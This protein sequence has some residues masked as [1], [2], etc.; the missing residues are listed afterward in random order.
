M[1]MREKLSSAA[2]ELEAAQKDLEMAQEK[3]N[4]GWYVVGTK[5]QLMEKGLVFKKGFFDDGDMSENVDKSLFKKVDIHE[6]NEIILD[7]RKAKLVT[8][9]PSESYEFIKMKKKVYRLVI[10]NPEKFWSVSKFLIIEVE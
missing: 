5:G 6:L 10:N 1:E 7:S 3:L 8:T 2:Q 4:T 9:H